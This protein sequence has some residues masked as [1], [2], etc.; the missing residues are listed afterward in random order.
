LYLYA[1][2]SAQYC[3]MRKARDSADLCLK[4]LELQRNHGAT[5]I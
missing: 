4:I 3:T 1:Y 2:I 5:V